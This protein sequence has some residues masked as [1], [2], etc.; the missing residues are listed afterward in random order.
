MRESMRGSI[1]SVMVMD[2][3]LSLGPATAPSI[4]LSSGLF[5]DQKSASASSLSKIGTSSHLAMARIFVLNTWISGGMG[6]RVGGGAGAEPA[7]LT[8]L[9]GTPGSLLLLGQCL[10]H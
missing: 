8:I 1:R 10:V 2:S 4:N 3:E 6:G 5:S 7:K 9:P